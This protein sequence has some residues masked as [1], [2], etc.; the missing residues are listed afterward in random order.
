MLTAGPEAR[1]YA[2]HLLDIA[3]SLDGR[4]APALA[5]TMARP[6]QVEGRLLA[7][8]DAARNRRAPS[9]RV[10]IAWAALAAAL[11]VPLASATTTV[12]APAAEPGRTPATA[13]WRIPCPFRT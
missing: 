12:A 6:S 7:A 3:Y 4:R 9:V 8:L 2:G 5:V 13:P 1:D 11:L 10:R